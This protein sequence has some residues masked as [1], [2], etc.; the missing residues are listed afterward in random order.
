MTRLILLFLF[1][2]WSAS[3]F[4]SYRVYK[5]KLV[6]YDNLGKVERVEVKLTNLDPYQYEHYHAITR[7]TAM[8][9]VY[10]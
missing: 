9:A 7:T 1:G 2:L 6:H 10:R 8:T 4:G 3:S 5:L